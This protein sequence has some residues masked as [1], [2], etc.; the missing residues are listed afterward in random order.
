MIKRKR[1]RVGTHEERNT[2]R[3]L[4]IKVHKKCVLRSDLKVVV[5]V[6]PLSPHKKV[7]QI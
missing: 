2:T 3:R 6:Q 1:H 5:K 4:H 7:Q